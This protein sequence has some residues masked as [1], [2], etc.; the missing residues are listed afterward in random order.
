MSTGVFLPVEIPTLHELLSHEKSL[1]L[2]F[3]DNIANLLVD[4]E[5]REDSLMKGLE[6]PTVPQVEKPWMECD[7]AAN[8][9]QVTAN[10]KQVGLGSAR[11][12]QTT[13]IESGSTWWDPTAE[14]DLE[15]VWWDPTASVESEVRG[16]IKSPGSSLE[17]WAGSDH[18]GQ[19]WKCAWDRTASVKWKWWWD[20]TAKVELASWKFMFCEIFNAEFQELLKISGI[21]ASRSAKS[22]PSVR[23]NDL[24]G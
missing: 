7:P 1:T 12:D 4:L 8:V 9:E 23:I 10:V 6:P 20:P 5:S 14:V 11:W 21:I 18:Q 19:A 15:S 22:P 16:G 13:G 3:A 2:P 17:V 24:I